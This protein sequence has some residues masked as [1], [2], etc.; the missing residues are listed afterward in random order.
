MEL[1]WSDRLKTKE[2]MRTQSLM[3]SKLRYSLRKVT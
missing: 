1:S 3:E 2:T